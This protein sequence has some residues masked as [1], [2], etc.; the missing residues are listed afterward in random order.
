M[1]TNNILPTTTDATTTDEE[2]NER[3]LPQ[4]PTGY[5]NSLVQKAL[6]FG[7]AGIQAQRE[8]MHES[9]GGIES[10][11]FDQM[12]R[13]QLQT[14]QDIA[15][16][17]M[18]ALRS[19][20]PSSQ[21]AAMELQNVQT[22]QLGA[23]E[24][25]R[26]YDQLRL[27]M[28]TALAGAEDMMAHDKFNTLAQGITD[29]NAIEA[30]RYAHDL[31]SQLGDVFGDSWQDMSVLTK[32]GMVQAITGVELSQDAKSFLEEIALE[33][34][35]NPGFWERNK[36]RV[37]QFVGAGGVM[38]G[39]L[40]AMAVGAKK[41]ATKGMLAGPKGIV[42]GA[43]VGGAAGLVVSLINEWRKNRE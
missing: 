17:R 39:V 25:A 22:A 11:L 31:N 29:M 35:L 1:P 20:M 10:S 14:E 26:E 6:G 34:E 43:A 30:Q 15:N 28:D 13:M 8:A 32:L 7:N 41:G 2:T 4:I 38:G 9:L 37:A 42:A 23:Q 36:D 40:T 33:G 27:E 12:G 19:G 16:R 5:N 18:Q 21:L 3:G 24:M